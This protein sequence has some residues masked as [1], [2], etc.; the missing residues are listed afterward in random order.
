VHYLN[1]LVPYLAGAAS[2]FAAQ[3]LIQVFVDP[4]VESRKRRDERW[5]KDVID[6][7]DLLTGPLRDAAQK[8]HSEQLLLLGACD[9]PAGT[10]DPPEKR[11]MRE[12]AISEQKQKT[13]DA[14]GAFVDL[15]HT[16]VDWMMQK[17]I[18]FRTDSKTTLPF[19][20]AIISYSLIVSSIA[21]LQA[22]EVSVADLEQAWSTEWEHRTEMIS[23]VKA[24]ALQPHAP[25]KSRQWQLQ[26]ARGR[27]AGVMRGSAW[28]RRP[29]RPE[30]NVVEEPPA[31]GAQSEAR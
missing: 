18:G 16:R 31:V 5:E 13:R 22:D 4:R 30:A 20:R 27:I 10:M 7:G 3:F 26:R 11:E 21:L 19:M 6:L 28:L 14:V 24:L 17:V 15:V 25:R 2:A 12:R 9:F 29:L 8:V 1:E 23:Q